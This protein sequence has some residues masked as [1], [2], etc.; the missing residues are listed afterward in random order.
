MYLD[1]SQDLD[2][3]DRCHVICQGTVLG[4]TSYKVT[5]YSNDITI[6]GNEAK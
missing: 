2:V 3:Q 1:T 6:I 4:V 5:D